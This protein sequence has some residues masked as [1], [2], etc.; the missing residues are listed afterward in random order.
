MKILGITAMALGLAVISNA[1][2]REDV[3]PTNLGFRVGV[4]YPLNDA[5]RDLT[6]TLIGAGADM[7][8]TTQWLKGS[9]TF[10]SFDWLGKSGNGAKGNIFPLILNQRWYAKNTVAGK[11]T[12]FHVGFGIAFVDITKS[13]TTLAARGGFGL[14]LGPNIS[15]EINFLLSDNANGAK[16]DSIGIYLGY[17]F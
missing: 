11:R 3:T 10:V 14:E 6:K 5:T 9:E 12:Y 17:R 7:Y 8:L 4:A 15:T 16:A 2:P 1:Q 13:R